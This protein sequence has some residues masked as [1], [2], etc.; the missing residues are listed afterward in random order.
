MPRFRCIKTGVCRRFFCGC[1]LWLMM[2]ICGGTSLQ[3]Q[4]VLPEESL[5]QPRKNAEED[6]RDAPAIEKEVQAAIQQL[7]T[8]SGRMMQPEVRDE[9]EIPGQK[10]LRASAARYASAEELVRIRG[11]LISGETIQGELRN[12][13]FR[14]ESKAG[15]FP[16]LLSELR[17]GQRGGRVEGFVFELTDGDRVTGYPLMAGLV[18]TMPEGGE[19]VLTL[20]ELETFE[21]LPLR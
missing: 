21:I 5:T 14:V 15:S 7:Q 9:D 17:Q 4:I 2:E 16:L 11:R 19:R 8:Q 13:S 1:R 18:L 3:A 6:V 10:L 20:R 12:R